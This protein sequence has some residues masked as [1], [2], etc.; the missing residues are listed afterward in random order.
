MYGMYTLILSDSAWVKFFA[1]KAK[2]SHQ[3]LKWG[4][5]TCCPSCL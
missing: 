2:D 4:N 1:S 3:N 5:W